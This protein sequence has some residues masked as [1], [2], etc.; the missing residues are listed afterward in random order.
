MG[1]DPSFGLHALAEL[2]PIRPIRARNASL[3]PGKAL[4]NSLISVA[5]IRALGAARSLSASSGINCT[6]NGAI[7]NDSDSVNRYDICYPLGGC[8]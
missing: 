5:A 6:P 3:L 7:A 1:L 2:T 4:R 8:G